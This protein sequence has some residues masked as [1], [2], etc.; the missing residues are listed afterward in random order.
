MEN[1]PK[2]MIYAH[3][4]KPFAGALFLRLTGDQLIVERGTRSNT[5]LLAGL[6]SI[7]LRYSPR[8]TARLAFTCDIRAKD[9]RKA[10]FDNISWKSLLETERLNTEFRGFV[11]E[12]VA[13]A[14]RANP[15]LRLERGVA[16]L[17]YW[18]MVGTGTLLVAGLIGTIAVALWQATYMVALFAAAMTAY[19]AHWLWDFLTRNRPGRFT[20]EAVPEAVLPPA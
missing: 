18:L 4:P 16:P 7:R 17:R 9:G 2:E 12:L 5:L 20:P 14:A 10:R 11:Q 15:H 19:L 1:Q 3:S 6:E 8:N 13:R